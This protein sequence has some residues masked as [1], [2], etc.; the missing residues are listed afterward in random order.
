[1]NDSQ[2]VSSLRDQGNGLDPDQYGADSSAVSGRTSQLG[3]DSATI[4]GIPS[5]EAIQAT[6]GK[7]NKQSVWMI[8]KSGH[9]KKIGQ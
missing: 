5:P 1:M 8:K 6:S 3:F 9:K 7:G 4:R 2:S